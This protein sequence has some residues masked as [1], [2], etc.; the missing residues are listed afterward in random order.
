MALAL[1]CVALLPVA[2]VV[3]SR[4]GSH[5]LPVQDSAVMDL[6]VRDVWSS[7]IPLTGAYSRYGWSHPGPWMYWLIA[8][9]TLFGQAAWATLVGSALLQGAAT[10]WLARLSWRSG[11]LPALALWLAISVLATSTLGAA[12]W[13]EPWNPYI[14]LPFLRSSCCRSGCW[15][16][17]TRNASSARRWSDHSSS[18]HTWAMCR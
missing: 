16:W 5:Y 12:G 7:D 10:V 6:R 11:G 8:P 3:F 9:F 14:A 17:A 1:T 18:K 2:V 4:W 13:L 15:R